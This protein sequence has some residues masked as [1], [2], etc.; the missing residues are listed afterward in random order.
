MEMLVQE[1]KRSD[2]DNANGTFR[3]T[4]AAN[5]DMKANRNERHQGQ[6]VIQATSKKNTSSG[7]L[8]VCESS[9]FPDITDSIYP[10]ARN[11]PLRL[12]V[13]VTHGHP[14]IEGL[15]TNHL[16]V[17]GRSCATPS[18]EHMHKQFHWP[19]CL[20]H[21]RPVL[22]AASHAK[23]WHF[24]L[25]ACAGCRPGARARAPPARRPFVEDF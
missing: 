23:E 13:L 7:M 22:H 17:L 9:L 21:L 12:L 2:A 19:R 20:L 18:E 8:A 4:Y 16:V 6:H 25:S 11:R 15:R 10:L 3:V 5:I 1:V 14:I 24:T